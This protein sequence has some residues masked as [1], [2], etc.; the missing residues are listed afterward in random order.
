MSDN[1]NNLCNCL[2]YLSLF[3][4]NN[5]CRSNKI[6]NRQRELPQSQKYRPHCPRCDAQSFGYCLPSTISLFLDVRHIAV[7][8]I[9]YI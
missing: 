2:L 3:L 1:M 9:T 4:V 6:H 8:Q 7:M 5:P